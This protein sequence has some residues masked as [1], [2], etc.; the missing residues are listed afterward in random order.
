MIGA[1][2]AYV[3]KSLAARHAEPL[4]SL[5]KSCTEPREQLAESA[6][7]ASHGVESQTASKLSILNVLHEVVKHDP[8]GVCLPAFTA[9]AKRH[10]AS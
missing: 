8:T 5:E 3:K 2:G 7:T 4:D 10:G 1:K 6:L 9:V